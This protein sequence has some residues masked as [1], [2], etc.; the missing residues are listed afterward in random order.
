V[1]AVKAKGLFGQN[2]EFLAIWISDSDNPICEESVRRL[3]SSEV[4]EEF[5]GEFGG[6]G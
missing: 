5:L 6:A 2:V 1:A 3:N 4:A